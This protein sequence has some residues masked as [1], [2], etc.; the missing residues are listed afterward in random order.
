MVR[1]LTSPTSLLRKPEKQLAVELPSQT[2]RRPAGPLKEVLWTAAA[3]GQLFRSQEA[4]S[5]AH[6]EFGSMC[7]KGIL[8]ID[9]PRGL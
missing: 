5:S 7:I 1:N 8:Y 3:R 2:T 4:T 9:K 6:V